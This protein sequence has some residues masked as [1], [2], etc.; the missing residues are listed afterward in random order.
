MYCPQCGSNNQDGLKFCTRCGVNL[1]ALSDAVSWKID[2]ATKVDERVVELLKN[3]YRG[4]RMT[5][6][7]LVLSALMTF[8]LTLGMLMGMSEQFMLL[9]AILGFFLIA[10]LFWFMWGAS[11]WNNASS[12]LKARGYDNPKSARPKAKRAADGLL[13]GSTVMVVKDH[14]TGPLRTD[15]LSPPSVTEQTTRFL[16]DEGGV[17]PAPREVSN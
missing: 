11:K 1:G 5:I 16:D 10:G 8:K 7:G 4:R 12:E 15:P 3:Y 17:N 9:L 6:L 13:E 14:A 2:P